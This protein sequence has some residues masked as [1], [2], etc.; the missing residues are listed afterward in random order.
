MQ[1]VKPFTK[2]IFSETVYIKINVN[3]LLLI[4][5]FM[6]YILLR[7]NKVNVILK[8]YCNHQ[9]IS[10]AVKHNSYYFTEKTQRKFFQLLAY[11]TNLS[12]ISFP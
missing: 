8:M 5:M 1:Q 9:D 2:C 7:S 11:L 12:G 10:K 6:K 4:H 3:P